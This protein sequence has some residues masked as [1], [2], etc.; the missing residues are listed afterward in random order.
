MPA[1]DS[2][3]LAALAERVLV[4]DG[5]MGTELMDMDL[6]DEAFGGSRHRG[7]NEAVV[8]FRP[9][10]IE[11]IH[12]RYFEAGAD[13]GETDSFTASRLKLD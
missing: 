5:A 10:L 11:T 9:Y 12:T 6:A 13:V 3:Y 8:L 2:A 4:F 7:C 1:M